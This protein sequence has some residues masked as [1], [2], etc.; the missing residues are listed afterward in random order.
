[1]YKGKEILA[2]KFWFVVVMCCLMTAPVVIAAEQEKADE[3]EDYFEMSIEEL[4]N[5]E[6]TSSARRPQPLTRATSAMYVITAEDIRQA[7]VTKMGDLFRLVPGMDVAVKR[8][9][10][11]AVS[12]RGFAITAS[13]RMLVLLDGRPLYEPYGGGLDFEFLPVF[14]EN[15]ERIEVIRGSAG[16]TWGVNAING[17][18]NIITKKPA[19]TQGFFGYGGFGNRDLQQGYIR[20]GGTNGPL[21]WRSTV[22]GFHDNGLGI[23]HGE[24][25]D[26]ENR[27]FMATGLF[28]L[29]LSDDKV[30]TFSGGHSGNNVGN[31][32]NVTERRFRYQYMN[33]SLEQMLSDDSKL[34]IR[35][36]ESFYDRD[37]PATQDRR[38][39]EDMIEIEHSFVSDNHGI[40]WGADYIRDTMHM[41]PLGTYTDI[42][43]PDDFRNDQASIFIQDE[44]TLADNLW[45][46]VGGR[47]HHN[48]LTHGDWAGIAALV[49]EVK[50]K[51]FI[52]GAVSR[53]F[54]R[55]TLREEFAYEENGANVIRGNED[56]WNETLT[57]YELGY[58]GQLAENLELNVE[59]F[60]NEHDNL[61]GQIGAKKDNDYFNTYDTRTY[62]V[63]TA[64]NWKPYQWWLV[65]GFHVYEHQTD[66]NKLGDLDIGK[67]SVYS[68]PKHKTGL[69][70]RFYLDKS[71]TLNTQLYWYDTYFNPGAKR[72]D[73]YCRFDVRLAKRIWNNSAEVAL[74]FTNLTDHFHNEGASAEVARQFYIQFFYEF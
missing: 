67:I 25:Y 33:M 38:T 44:I 21:T 62:G 22:G 6:V 59:G 17:V 15:I 42:A 40:V 31:G 20:Y 28:E 43:N 37:I 45:F 58:R 54:R 10:Q 34:A 47:L 69:T 18:I 5:V 2:S 70:N 39:R 63:E 26:D 1:M 53:S 9:E 57:S 72:V 64:F 3:N 65:R 35:W 48:E 50:P 8:G 16:V 23:E 24:A 30:L 73:P 32:D 56:L 12:A 71:T 51:H 36:F 49:W 74:G 46:T 52:R 41:R 66:E 11:V 60:V 19:D 68:V 4:M 27:K 29:K 55:P 7:G 61:I 13:R 14:P